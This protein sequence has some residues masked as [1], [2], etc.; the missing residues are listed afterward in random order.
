MKCL[1]FTIES[2][3]PSVQRLAFESEIQVFC[4]LVTNISCTDGSLMGNNQR[5]SG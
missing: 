1:Y 4:A 3:Q 2:I 5:N